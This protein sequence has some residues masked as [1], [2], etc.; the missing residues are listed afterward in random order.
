M[1]KNVHFHIMPYNALAEFLTVPNGWFPAQLQLL[2]MAS[3]CPLPSIIMTALLSS[4][5]TGNMVTQC[6]KAPTNLTILGSHLWHTDKSYRGKTVTSCIQVISNELWKGCQNQW[7]CQEVEAWAESG[8]LIILLESLLSWLDWFVL[9][10]GR[11]GRG[12]E[13]NY[14]LGT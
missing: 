12:R 10:R 9:Q 7:I 3:C 2:L 13:A 11:G 6:Y 8:F 5:M 1:G 14:V 4:T